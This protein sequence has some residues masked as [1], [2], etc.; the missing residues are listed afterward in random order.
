MCRCSIE[1]VFVGATDCWQSGTVSAGS[2][3]GASLCSG[4]AG[5]LGFGF[6]VSFFSGFGLQQDPSWVVVG[7]QLF[8]QQQEEEAVSSDTAFWLTGT[9]EHAQTDSGKLA[10][11]V[12]AAVANTTREQDILRIRRIVEPTYIM[13]LPMQIRQAQ[14]EI[15]P[16]SP[17]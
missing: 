2:L 16:G 10:S 5:C 17:A 13:G 7:Q 9:G 12:E 15:K 3:G 6:V 11:S 4:A 14:R 1:N 8:L